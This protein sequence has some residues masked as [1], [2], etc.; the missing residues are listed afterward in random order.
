MTIYWCPST[1][2]SS[3]SDAGREVPESALLRHKEG[4]SSGAHVQK[5]RASTTSH[6]ASAWVLTHLQ[7]SGC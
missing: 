2:S 1:S 3:T 6:M 5:L 4:P 7:D